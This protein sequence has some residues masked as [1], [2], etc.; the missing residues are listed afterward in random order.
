MVAILTP[1][2]QYWEEIRMRLAWCLFLFLLL[3][4]VAL[5][6]S[7]SL[8]GLI[9]SWA[10]RHQR[11]PTPMVVFSVWDG[12]QASI[13]LAGY[14]AFIGT[15]PLLICELY[16]F[17]APALYPYERRVVAGFASTGLFLFYLGGYLAWL[18]VLP[19]LLYA[20]PMWLPAQ[21]LW[22]LEVTDFTKLVVVCVGYGGLVAQ[23]PALLGVFCYLGYFDYA[24]VR[25]A[26]G[27]VWLG[28]FTVGMVITPPDM[29]L[30]ML[31]ALPLC[32]LYEIIVV[33]LW[34]HSLRLVAIRD[35]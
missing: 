20:L 9:L 16:R 25:A 32:L 33:G 6:Y 12:F 13:H 4:S 23:M 1:Y 19:W 14:T 26:R 35:T 15:L 17:V 18:Y 2:L 10:R 8:F 21:A 29:F 28:T 5:C 3:F 34:V 7:D 22:V 11:S 31:V 27:Y 30:Q 24:S